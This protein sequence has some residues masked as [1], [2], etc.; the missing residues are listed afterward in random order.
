MENNFPSLSELDK[1]YSIVRQYAHRTPVM[2]SSA[3]NEIS[4]A[5]LYF[6]C[7]N[8]QRGGAFKF[9]GATNA[10]LSLPKELL[11]K[12]LATHSSG[13]HA[14][15]LCIVAKTLGVPAYIVMPET[16][17]AI[18]VA[19]V[20]NYG[21][22]IFFCKPT[23]EARESTLNQVVEET[24]S[25]FI[26]PYNSYDIIAGQ[27]TACRELLEEVPDLDSVIAPVGGGG[28]LSGTALTALNFGK[29]YITVYASEPDGADDAFRSIRDGY[30]HPSVNPKTIA[31]GLLTSLGDKTYPIIK[32]LV[33]EI[34][35]VSDHEI[36]QAM[37]LIWER[38]KII[39]EPSGA[40][41]LAA[42]LKSG[43]LFRGKKT[44]LILSGG[45]VDI[46]NINWEF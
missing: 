5:E 25:T 9:R 44:G 7:E 26:H 15:A 41:V 4:G 42:V 18:K 3:I 21:G 35:T 38:M 1:A 40:T 11:S 16:A 45:N 27:S 43:D 36:T 20:K 23:L 29:N 12:G 46:P 17:P 14:A 13:N 31:D 24:G 32:R 30:I 6:K 22:K 39:V 33:S 37:K 10:A 2:K 34:I 8:F 19:A 28:L